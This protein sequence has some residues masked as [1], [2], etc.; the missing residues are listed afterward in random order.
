M[1][2][3]GWRRTRVPPEHSPCS[4]SWPRSH[5]QPHLCSTDIT[6]SQPTAADSSSCA[7]IN[8][9]A[10][11]SQLRCGEQH[12]SARNSHGKPDTNSKAAHPPRRA[13]P[14]C[15][16]ASHSNPQLQG[17]KCLTPRLGPVALALCWKGIP[18][19]LRK[20][21][22]TKTPDTHTFSRLCVYLLPSNHIK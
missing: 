1:S 14:R 21:W 15:L 7:P 19:V 6:S 3:G 5:S 4:W 10:W 22:K 13:K 11:T 17:K 8:H 9:P 20:H 18:N 16:P 12:R 2:L